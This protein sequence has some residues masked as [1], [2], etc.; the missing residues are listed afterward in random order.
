MAVSDVIITKPGGLT[1][2]E[3]LVMGLPMILISAIFGQE[4]RNI[5]IMERYGAG[6]SI[7]HIKSIKDKIIDYMTHPEQLNAVK[8]KI[9]QVKRP[10]AAKEISDVVC[11][12]SIRVAH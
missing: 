8:E 10:N 7:T 5:E 2:S 9:A 6:C 3:S 11:Q 1:I 12:G 4:T